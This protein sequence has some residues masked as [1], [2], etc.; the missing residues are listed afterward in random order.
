MVQT[1]IEVSSTVAIRSLRPSRIAYKGN[2]SA[3]ENSDGSASYGDV[4]QPV[5]THVGK[6]GR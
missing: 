3:S 2:A 5:G 4:V 6:P 1:I